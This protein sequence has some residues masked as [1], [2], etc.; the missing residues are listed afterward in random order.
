VVG[1]GVEQRRAWDLVPSVP[2]F[3]WVPIAEVGQE[4]EQ[5]QAW[6][7]APA[8]PWFGWIPVAEVEQE[9]GQRPELGSERESRAEQE[10]VQLQ[11]YG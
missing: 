8:A 6:D 2:W 11:G 7:L 9:L 1:Q 5:L 10:P 4:V 3:G